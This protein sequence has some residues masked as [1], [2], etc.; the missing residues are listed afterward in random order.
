MVFE[1]D[2]LSFRLIDVLY[3]DDRGTVTM[4]TKARPFCA[5]S[6]RIK[7]DADIYM[8]GEVIK[9][10][11]HDLS[12]FPA[13]RPYTR[14]AEGDQM[15][16]FHFFAEN[17]VTYGIEVLH[18]VGFERLLPLFEEA[19]RVW[20][21]REPG[22]R[23]R[24]SA[25]LY[26]VFAA[27][28][29]EL[30]ARPERM[31]PV[32]YEALAKISEHYADPSLSVGLLAS[33]AHMSDTWFRKQF[34]RDMGVPPKKYINDLRLDYANSLLGAGYD[35]VAGVAV[36]SGFRDA[37]NFSTAFKKRFGYPPGDSRAGKYE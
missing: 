9:L 10:T 8:Q 34:S 33:E 4:K 13:N 27:I 32:V 25:I 24:A 23:Y 7:G 37:K 31:N 5:L 2:D 22:Y 12:F 16:V 18:D 11:A 29:E 19:L 36:K 30:G 15:I 21:A 6:L 1:R 35:T 28:R 20:R 26:E 14:K 3:F 17:C